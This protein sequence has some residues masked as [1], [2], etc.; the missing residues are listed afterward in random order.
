MT[1]VRVNVS[2]GETHYDPCYGKCA[3]GTGS[4]CHLLWT[5]GHWDRVI[6]S[7]VMRG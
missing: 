4:L 3:T 6:M 5:I 2:L 1:L 7:L